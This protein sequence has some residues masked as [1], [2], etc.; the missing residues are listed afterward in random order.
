MDLKKL[1]A[2]LR[3]KIEQVSSKIGD[4][5]IAK[6]NTVLDDIDEGAGS[7]QHKL[8]KT[9]SESIER[10]ETIRDLQKSIEKKDGEISELNKRPDTAELEQKITTL[11]ETNS[12]LLQGQKDSFATKFNTISKHP[13]FDKVK[14]F[15]KLPEPEKDGSYDLSK[16]EG[17]D[18]EYNIGKLAEHEAAEIFG[19]VDKPSVYGSPRLEHPNGSEKPQEIKS[20]EDLMSEFDKG[21]SELE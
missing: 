12:R 11:T 16:M 7:L 2:R 18:L 8:A 17:E 5:D 15:Y 9:E 10:K 20:E 19:K 21:F 3:A 4:E 1:L 6:I 14:K 13:K